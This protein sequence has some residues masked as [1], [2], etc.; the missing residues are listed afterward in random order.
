SSGT[1][2]IPGR[3]ALMPPARGGAGGGSRSGIPL[4]RPGHFSDL[5]QRLLAGYRQLVQIALTLQLS[6]RLAPGL[7]QLTAGPAA[8]PRLPLAH[9]ADADDAIPPVCF[10]VRLGGLCRDAR[11]AG[12]SRPEPGHATAPLSSGVRQVPCH[13]WPRGPLAQAVPMSHQMPAVITQTSS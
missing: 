12:L 7:V 3:A 10:L 9:C 1:G 6:G 13:Q 8:L 4:R 2:G 5:E 11:L